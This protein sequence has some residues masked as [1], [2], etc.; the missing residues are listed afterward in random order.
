MDRLFFGVMG[1]RDAGKS[2]TWNSLFGREVRTGKRPRSL[3]LGGG[4]CAEVFLISGSPEE[5]HEYAGDRL[6]DQECRIVLCSMQYIDTVRQTLAY[7]VGEG[8]DLHVQWLNPGHDDP[9]HV[10]DSLG[11]APWL[12][13]HGA[14]LSI[15]DGKLTPGR[16]VGEIRQTIHGWARARGLT[17]RCP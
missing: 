1:H 10:P 17:F 4:E 14:T 15:R 8:F 2:T 7:V 3:E 9:G 12:L 11:L 5:R 16:R 6:A 13:H